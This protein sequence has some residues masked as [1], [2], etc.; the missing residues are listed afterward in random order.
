MQSRLAPK[1]LIEE[2]P[3]QNPLQALL[4]LADEEKEVRGIR[5]TPREI[6]QQPDTWQATY[7]KCRHRQVE[8]SSFQIGRAH[9]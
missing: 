8:I 7:G 4:E 5:Y 9:V 6:S 1:I 2:D 3:L